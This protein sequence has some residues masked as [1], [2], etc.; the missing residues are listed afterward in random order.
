MKEYK[1]EYI[2]LKQKTSETQ[3]IFNKTLFL[4]D[5]FIIGIIYL[6]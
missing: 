5:Q 1:I 6:I 2:T 3:N 4:N